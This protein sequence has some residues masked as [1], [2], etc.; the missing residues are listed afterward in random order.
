MR[1]EFNVTMSGEGDTPEECWDDAV[2]GFMQEP[3]PCPDDDKY[4]VVEED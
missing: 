3:G 2:E 4:E 1:C